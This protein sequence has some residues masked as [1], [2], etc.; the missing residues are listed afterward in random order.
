MFSRITIVSL[1][2][3]SGR[4]GMIAAHRSNRIELILALHFE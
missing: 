1:A 3:R 2:L 4:D